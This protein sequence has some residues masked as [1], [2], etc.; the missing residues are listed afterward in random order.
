MRTKLIDQHQHQSR[1]VVILYKK[2][3]KT[4]FNNQE[5]N[6]IQTKH[7]VQNQE[8]YMVDEDGGGTGTLGEATEV[9]C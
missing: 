5:S 9:V 8:N 4:Q 1:K 7:I 6:D 2:K 3:E